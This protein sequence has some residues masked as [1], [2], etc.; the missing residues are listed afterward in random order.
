MRPLAH[1][2][3]AVD[4]QAVPGPFLGQTLTDYPLP[5]KLNFFGQQ[6]AVFLLAQGAPLGVMYGKHWIRN[7]NELYDDPARAACRATTCPDANF[8]VNEEGYVVEKASWRCG[9]DLVYRDTGA[10][11]DTPER[12]IAYVNCKTFNTDGS[13][14]ATTDVVEIGNANPDFNLAFSSGFNY[15]R[16]SFTG[17]VDWTQGGSIYNG[18]R[19]WK[20]INFFDTIFDR[21]AGS[22]YFHRLAHCPA[23]AHK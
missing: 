2:S 23:A 7:I 1:Q 18:T 11:C 21:R 13:C 8:T 15:K 22:K 19:Q 14:K 9:E 5:E 20:L 6:P 17:L 10:A 16:L 12:L 4:L 3:A